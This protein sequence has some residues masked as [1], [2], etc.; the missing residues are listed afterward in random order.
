MK[1]KVSYEDAI[2]ELEHIVNQL[3]SGDASL[4]NSLK[5]FDK[6]TKLA[7]YCYSALNS[8]EQKITELS[9]IEAEAVLIMYLI[10]I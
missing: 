10:H 2:H 3:E 5:L 8:A 7:S 9:K 6:G 1:S 4:E